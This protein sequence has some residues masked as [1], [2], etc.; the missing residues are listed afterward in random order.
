MVSKNR[1]INLLRGWPS[2]SL[3]PTPLIRQ[4]A[5]VALSD[6]AVAIPGLLYGPDPGFQPLREEI[7][8]WMQRFYGGRTTPDADRICITGG[9]SQNLA[10]VLQVYTDPVRTRVWMVAPCYF[11]ACRIF[12]DAGLRM[13]A[14]PEGDEGVDVEK[15]EDMMEKAERNEGAIKV[16]NKFSYSFPILNP[17]VMSMFILAYHV[18]GQQRQCLKNNTDTSGHRQSKH[19]HHGEDF[20]RMLYI[21]YPLSAIHLARP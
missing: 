4:A 19:Q 13:S 20:T 15:L 2:P 12:E 18:V 5:Q 16:S 21:V 6:S 17:S 7:A 8:Q 11:M 1:P 9:A 10:C 14:A 3:L